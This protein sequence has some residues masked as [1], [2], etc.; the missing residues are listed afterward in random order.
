ME[1]EKKLFSILYLEDDEGDVRRFAEEIKT[2][3]QELTGKAEAMMT[4]GESLTGMLAAWG[5]KW[6][7]SEE[8]FWREAQKKEYRLMII[9]LFFDEKKEVCGMNL[10]EKLEYHGVKGSPLIWILSRLSHYRMVAADQARVHRFFSKDDDGLKSMRS[11]LAKVFGAQREPADGELEFL[12]SYGGKLIVRAS[13]IIAIDATSAGNSKQYRQRRIYCINPVK[14]FAKTEVIGGRYDL[15]RDVQQQ[16]ERKRIRD[17]VQVS[18]TTMINIR[19][20]S[21]MEERQKACYLTMS[22]CGENKESQIKV[23]D[24]YRALL[25]SALGM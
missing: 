21:R 6:V 13:Q 10:I 23:G 4:Y 15:M 24:A 3:V 1:E 14:S 7:S 19:H 9:D 2:V 8:V 20:I 5:I 22:Q 11:L 18:R 12:N 16:I 25:S 17:L